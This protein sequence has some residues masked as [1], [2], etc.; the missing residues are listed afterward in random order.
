MTISVLATS[1][2]HQSWRRRILLAFI[3]VALA[4]GGIVFWRGSAYAF[5]VSTRPAVALPMPVL[6]EPLNGAITETAI[7]AGGCFWGVQGVFQRVKG[8]QD[9]VS[10]YA[11]GAA[12][13]AHYE[14]VS[15]GGT[16]HAESVEVV[17]DPTKV[18][19]GTLLRVFFSVVHDPTELN[20]Q[21]PDTGTQYRSA[22]FPTSAEQ[23]RVARAYIAQ[24]EA[25]HAFKRPIV[26]RI[27]KDTGFFPAENYHQN[28]LVDH[29]Q[30]PYIVINDLP[31]VAQLK[32]VFP[33]LYRDSPV[34]VALPTR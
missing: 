3:F 22:I 5:G 21:G 29:P 18:S 24:L 19:Y 6:D 14:I 9:A 11:G 4:C 17:F 10:G 27:E 28:F 30:Y 32:R 16:G 12:S 31:K 25:A 1:P 20:R 13:T 34:L 7:F 2:A 15:S 23:G 26:T 8:V 33:A